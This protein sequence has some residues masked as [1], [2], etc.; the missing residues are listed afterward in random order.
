MVKSVMMGIILVGMDVHQL[1]KL[2]D[3]IYVM[4]NQVSVYLIY[5]LMESLLVLKD[6]VVTV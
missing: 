6:M 4:M 2:N 3:I 5:M 1:A